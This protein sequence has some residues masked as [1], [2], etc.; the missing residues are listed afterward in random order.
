M[1][2]LAG[3]MGTISVILFGATVYLVTSGR[4]RRK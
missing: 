3:L 2:E 1:V 4:E